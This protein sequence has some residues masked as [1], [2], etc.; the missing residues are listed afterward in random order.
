[1]AAFRVNC[2]LP[3]STECIVLRMREDRKLLS[4]SASAMCGLSCSSALTPCSVPAVSAAAP[5]ALT[6][7]GLGVLLAAD[8]ADAGRH[9]RRRS[10]LVT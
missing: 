4:K 1:M 7:R 5:A 6:P 9:R 3:Y 2:R 8:R 10:R